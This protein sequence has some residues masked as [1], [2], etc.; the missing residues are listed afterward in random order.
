MVP[1]SIPFD[2][3]HLL[4]LAQVAE[5]WGCKPSDLLKLPINLWQIDAA[6]ARELWAWRKKL[7]END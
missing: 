7:N 1:A 2:P 6:C 3:E 4:H 5:T